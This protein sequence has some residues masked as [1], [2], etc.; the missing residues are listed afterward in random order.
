MEIIIFH[1]LF[2]YVNWGT[3]YGTDAESVHTPL[4]VAVAEEDAI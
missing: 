4:A 3:V 1:F 2:I